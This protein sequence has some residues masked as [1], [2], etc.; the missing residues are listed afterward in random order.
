V[1]SLETMEARGVEAEAQRRR[2]ELLRASFHLLRPGL[3]RIRV[4]DFGADPPGEVEITLDPRRSPGEQVAACFRAARKAGRA[5]R[6]ARDRL[7][8]ARETLARLETLHRAAEAATDAEALAAIARETG[9]EVAAGSGGRPAPP[10]AVPW[11]VF[12]SLD[13]WRILVGRSAAGNDRLTLH[14]ARPSDLFLHVRGTGG[15]HVIVPVPRGRS[16]PRD[17]LLDA[18]ELAAWFSGLRRAPRVEVDYTERRYVRKPRGAPAGTV[19]LERYK[20]L[21]LRR[22]D[23]RRERV[24]GSRGE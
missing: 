3:E 22:E 12:R 18:A 20:T 16:V 5:A 8:A 17:T 6:E 11:R 23:D 7:P 13:G 1:A 9:V 15:S 21:S 19:R 14:E 24:L 2:G 10:R 4:P